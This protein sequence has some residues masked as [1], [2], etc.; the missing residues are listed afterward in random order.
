MIPLAII[1]L[2]ITF[3]RQFFFKEKEKE[4]DAL[5]RIRERGYLVAL[6]DKNSVNYFIYKGLPM[7]YQLEL[8]NSFAE[9]LD[10]PLKIITDNDVSRLF[11]YLDLNAGDL[12]ALNL[13][14]T[15][16]G[17]KELHFSDPFGETRMVLV[18]RRSNARTGQDTARYIRS[19]SDFSGD[20]VCMRNNLLDEPVL[21]TFVRKTGGSIILKKIR[22]KN[23]LELIGLVSEQKINYAVCDENLAMV[24]KRFYRNIDAG[25]VIT[26]LYEYGWGVSLASDSLRWMINDWLASRKKKE[27]KRLYLAYYNNPRI[28]SYFQSDYCSLNGDRLSPYDEAIRAHSKRISWD[29]RLLA[30]LIYEETNFLQGQVSSRNAQGLM[31]LMPETA[32]KFGMD[33]SSAPSAQILA[34]VKYIEWIDRQLPAEIY[35][36]REKINFILASYNVGIGRVLSAREKAGKYGKDKNRWI[37][38]VDYYLTRKSK[39]E[40]GQLQDTVPGLLLYSASGGFVADILERYQHYRNL[41]PQ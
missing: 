11:Y 18:Q 26:K 27:L 15:R 8:L 29:W 34:G 3:G 40:P 6:T 32:E 36:P 35:D 12:L 16:E 37:G 5:S 20:T 39:K 33:S 17:K 7:G 38:N 13:P 10:V 9:Y 28:T 24:A 30:S 21:Q 14:V 22:V 31:Q 23:N 19:L 1:I 41:I 25:L 2:V 4:R